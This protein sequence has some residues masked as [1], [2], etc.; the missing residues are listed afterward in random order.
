[1]SVGKYEVEAC[2]E[3]VFHN[4]LTCYPKL[5]PTLGR[6]SPPPPIMLKH[7][8]LFLHIFHRNIHLFR[9]FSA[10]CKSRR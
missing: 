6:H 8:S 5:H 10:G 9:D 4:L 7:S 2:C 3:S 1:M